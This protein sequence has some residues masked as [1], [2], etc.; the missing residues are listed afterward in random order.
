MLRLSQTL[1][2]LV[3]F[4]TPLELSAQFDSDEILQERQIFSR[5]GDIPPSD[6]DYSPDHSEP[7]EYLLRETSIEFDETER[8]IVA[9]I[10]Y[11]VRIKILTDDPI[12]QTEAA[13]VGIPYYASD[14]ME[15]VTNFEGYTWKPDGQFYRIGSQDIRNAE[16]N[17]RYRLVEF[18]FPAVERGTI[19]EY[20]YTLERR[21][22]EELPDV[23][24][25]DRVPVREANI[26][27]KNADYLRYN[28]L[29]EN[30]DFDLNY[31]EF[32]VDT[33]SV[34]LVFT[35]ERPD[36]VSVEKWSAKQIP[37]VETTSYIS[38]ID[39]I[40]AKLKFQI[41]EFGLPRQPLE[42]SW[43]LVAAQLRR[44]SNP[45]EVITNHRELL[46]ELSESFKEI[47]DPA[48]RRDSI[49]MYVNSHS[50]FN[51]IYTLYA[52]D[53]LN[54]IS[55]DESANQAE[56][57]TLLLG[58]LR[59]NNIEAYPV[60]VSSRE[61]GRINQAFPSLYQFN[62]VLV[63]ADVE[64]EKTIMDASFSHSLPGLIPV[65]SYNQQGFVLKQRDFEW[66]SI[67]PDKSV[68]NLFVEINGALSESGALRGEIV[69]E[70]AGYPSREIR[71]SIS[72]GEPEREIIKKIFLEVYSDATLQNA[73]IEIDDEDPNIVR[74]QSG[75]EI[76]NY[77]VSYTDGLDYRPMLV[78]YLY[79]N[80]FETTSRRVPI[81]LDAPEQLTVQ[82]NISLP[83]NYVSESLQGEQRT[84]L[85]DAGLRES[86]NISGNSLNYS[87][88]VEI[89]RKQFSPDEYAQLRRIYQRWVEL[90]NDTWFIE[91]DG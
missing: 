17:S 21:Y 48:A 32:R 6:F 13:L 9:Y 50:R 42:N 64:R 25:S 30:V 20:K 23:Y 65:D 2:A 54:Y 46:E 38:S 81:T 44:N 52:E 43:E 41:S 61:S 85:S 28:I 26:Y 59:H 82:Y 60:F 7:Y 34:P 15:R 56:I 76:P 27:L 83:N 68:F 70:T 91:I 62:R 10:H 16:L 24:L 57:N 77:A 22:I 36:P 90:S 19:L 40:R 71:R 73:N 33:S 55:N 31:R 49:L 86:Y 4:A 63:V 8:G 5:F 89:G 66:A 72:V 84:E 67:S 11:L 37:A 18:E 58:L 39:D 45:F 88:E 69:A 51:G 14:N 47:G 3:I 1:L 75:F 80:P 12:R 79:Q 87:F 29:E 35:Y 74:I 78:G 53:G